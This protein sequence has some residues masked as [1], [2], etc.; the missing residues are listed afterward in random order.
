MKRAMSITTILLACVLLTA[1]FRECGGGQQHSVEQNIVT[2]IRVTV[3]AVP[4]GVETMRSLRGAG[5]VDASTNLELAQTAR[6][7]NS[8]L[9]AFT[10]AA[11]ADADSQDLLDK[12][13]AAVNLAADLEKQRT[14]PPQ[15]TAGRS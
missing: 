4:A 7:V 6:D 3:K 1:G 8:A 11:L 14:A 9:Q 12:L 10:K 5:L 15:R 2:G 13:D